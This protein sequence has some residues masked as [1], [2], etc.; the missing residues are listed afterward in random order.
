LTGAQCFILNWFDYRWL[1]GE[2]VFGEVYEGNDSWIIPSDGDPS[3]GEYYSTLRIVDNGDLNRQFVIDM[4]NFMRATSERVEIVYTQFF[5]RFLVEGDDTRW[6]LL[7]GT[8]P[9]VVANGYGALSDNT[10]LQIATVENEYS[11]D[12]TR[13]NSYYKISGVGTIGVL[14]YLTD[15][16]NYY[17]FELQTE[18][19]TWTLSKLVADTPTVIAT[20]DLPYTIHDDIWYGVRVHID[21]DGANNRIKIYIDGALILDELDSSLT[22]GTIG[23]YSEN[24]ATIKLDETELFQLP[25]ET[26]LVDINS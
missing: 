5:D 25:L 18:S 16:E 12:W 21:E 3:Y 7:T 23:F 8:T 11:A 4:V 9:M 26:D 2:T 6:Q 13:Y 14:F 20:D 1:T 22:K 24:G 15:D 10:E 17:K 19:P